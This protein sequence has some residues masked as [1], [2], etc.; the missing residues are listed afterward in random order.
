M[1]ID[2]PAG[3]LLGLATALTPLAGAESKIQAVTLVEVDDFAVT[4]LHLALFGNQT[5]R[6]PADAQGQLALLN[7]LVNHFMVANSTEGQALADRPEVVA[8]LE[9]ARARLLAQTF[10]QQQLEQIE[11]Y[12]DELRQ[13]YDA[14]YGD[15]DDPPAF[16]TARH[17]LEREIQRRRIAAVIDRIRADTR[18]EVQD[19]E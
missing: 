4:N 18:I 13:A 9:V 11:I 14:R 6:S 17:E 12:D 3:L 2:F 19:L 8:A 5:G 7:E 15:A 10:V 16:E 1:R